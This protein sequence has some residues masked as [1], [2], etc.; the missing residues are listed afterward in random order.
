MMNQFRTILED[1][2]AGDKSA[3]IFLFNQYRPLLNH[4]SY[5]DG[6]YDEDL[7]QALSIAFLT[8]V[9]KFRL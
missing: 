2:K 6:K 8:A 4:L 1:A 9:S 3:L 7:F 5:H